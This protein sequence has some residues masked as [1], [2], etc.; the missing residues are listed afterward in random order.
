MLIQLF[1]QSA[2]MRWLYFWMYLVFLLV[3]M[4]AAIL[5]R[6][7]GRSRC[8]KKLGMEPSRIRPG[9]FSLISIP[10]FLITGGFWPDPEKPEKTGGAAIRLALA[11]TG[12]NLFGAAT[13]V[14]GYAVTQMV[15]TVAPW[16]GLNWLYNFFSTFVMANVACALFPLLPLPGFD[17]GKLIAEALPQRWKNFFRVQNSLTVFLGLLIFLLLARSGITVAVTRLPLTLL[18]SIV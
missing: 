15:W 3:S 12:R 18:D 16:E 17:G 10:L 7:L 11:G 2:G 4:A 6:R 1:T 5:V 13:G 14:V 9:K 8:R